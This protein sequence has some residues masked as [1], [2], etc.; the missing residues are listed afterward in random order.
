MSQQNRMKLLIHGP[1]DVEL[2][3]G[4]VEVYGSIMHV[5]C[6]EPGCSYTIM[7]SPFGLCDIAITIGDLRASVDILGQGIP[8][9]ERAKEICTNHYNKVMR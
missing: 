5:S 2:N 6:P 3:W 9:L 7:L 1:A 4:E 8:T